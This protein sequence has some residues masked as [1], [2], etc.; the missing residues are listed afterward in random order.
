MNSP[1]DG[2]EP[3]AKVSGLFTTTHWSVVLAAGQTDAPEAGQALEKLCRTYWYP[4]YAY[5]RR[6]GS[7]RPRTPRT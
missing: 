1:S 4:L 6:R 7:Q 2:V 5:V 3:S